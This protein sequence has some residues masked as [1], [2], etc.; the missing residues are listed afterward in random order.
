MSATLLGELQTGCAH[1]YI[2]CFVRTRVV[3]AL[4]ESPVGVL[5]CRRLLLF[6]VYCY[7][8]LP[9]SLAKVFFTVF[10]D[11]PSANCIEVF[12]L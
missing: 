12:Y 1:L 9:D 7:H 3:R 10:F 6:I 5:V 4:V 11:L 8:S 2:S